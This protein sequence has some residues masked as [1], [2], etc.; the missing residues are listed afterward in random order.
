MEE[1]NQEVIKWVFQVRE[2]DCEQ[3][4]IKIKKYLST[5]LSFLKMKYRIA[6]YDVDEIEQECLCVLRFDIIKDF[7]PKK[8][9]FLSFAILCMKRHLF[10]AIKATQQQKRR[11]LNESISLNQERVGGEEVSLSELMTS[12]I[13]TLDIVEQ[14][15][16]NEVIRKTIFNSLTKLE[17]QTLELHLEGYTY[18][19]I[20]KIVQKNYINKKISGKTIDNALLRCRQ[21]CKKLIPIV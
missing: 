14:K 18:E 3:S 17:K 8:G 6:G 16:S 2:N 4:F 15:D 1:Q 21:K 11:V 13:S 19:D 9:N 12:G 7:D 5:Q 10:T 20:A